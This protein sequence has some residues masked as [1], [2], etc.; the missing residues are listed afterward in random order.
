MEYGK[1]GEPISTNSNDALLSEVRKTNALLNE[2]LNL[3]KSY[4]QKYNDEIIKEQR[5]DLY[6]PRGNF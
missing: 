5:P 1:Y 2:L 3:F 6:S 4:D